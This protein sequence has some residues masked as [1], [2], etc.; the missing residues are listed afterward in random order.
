MELSWRQASSGS[1]PWA[2]TG[3]RSVTE[4][5]CEGINVVE[6]GSARIPASFAGML[7]ADKGLEW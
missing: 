5:V 2:R 6:L 7:L 4:A 1:R 3:V